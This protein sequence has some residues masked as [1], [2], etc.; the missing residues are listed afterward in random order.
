MIDGIGNAIVWHIVDLYIQPPGIILN[1]YIWYP[2][3]K[4]QSTSTPRSDGASSEFINLGM[5]ATNDNSIAFADVP[6][7]VSIPCRL[8]AIPATTKGNIMNAGA[9]SS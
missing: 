8:Y 9:L 2:G 3:T 1:V 4:F 7:I 6:P 5:L